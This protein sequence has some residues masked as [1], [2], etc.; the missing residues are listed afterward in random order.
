[1]PSVLGLDLASHTGFAVVTGMDCVPQF[2]WWDAPVEPFGVY[3]KRFSA[4]HLWLEE[5]QSVHQFDGIA[6]ECPIK[7]PTD[8][9]STLRLLMG[10]SCIV[11]EFAGIVERRR[12]RRFP[13]LEVSVQDVKKALT[14][15]PYASKPDMK[16]AATRLGWR[17][18][19]ADQADAGSVAFT[20][21]ANFWPDLARAAA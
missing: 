13:C 6:F 1:M 3:K 10:F 8:K 21:F 14:G 5:M 19:D 12:G 7:K 15:N 2:G 18:A 16:H 4:L 9:T 11:E 20:A 17:V